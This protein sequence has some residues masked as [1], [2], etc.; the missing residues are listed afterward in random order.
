MGQNGTKKPKTLAYLKNM[1]YLCKIKNK[2]QT[3]PDG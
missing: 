1:P 2:T 3:A